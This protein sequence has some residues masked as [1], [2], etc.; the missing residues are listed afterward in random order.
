MSYRWLPRSSRFYS[1]TCTPKYDCYILNIMSVNGRASA[2][3]YERARVRVR[4]RLHVR[5][6]VCV[7]V[8]VRVCIGACACFTPPHPLANQR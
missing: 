2:C 4:A 8:P 3:Q 1:D 7:F 6:R 5:V